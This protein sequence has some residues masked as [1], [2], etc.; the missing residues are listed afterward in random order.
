MSALRG[1]SN[2]G[3]DLG[4]SSIKWGTL[5]VGDVQAETMTTSGNVEIQGNL[6]VTGTQTS[7]QVST[8]EA[9]DPLIKLARGN[10]GDTLDIGF[11]GQSNDGSA[12]YHGLFRDQ[13]DSGK[14]KLFKDLVSE[15]S[16]TVGT[17][18]SSHKATLVAHLEGNVTGDL[19][20][21]ADTATALET[22]RNIAVSGDI[23]GT[24]SFDGTGNIS[25]A[26]TIQEDAV[27]NSMILNPGYN[28][29]DG[30]TPGLVELGN[31]ITIQGTSNEVEV[32]RSSGTFTVG[33]PSTV[34]GLSS[35]SA[36]ALA[37]ELTGNASTATKLAT[38]RAIQISGDV[39]GSA[40][41]DGSAAINIAATIQSG[42][43]ENSMLANDGITLTVDGTGGED[44]NLG[45]SLDFNGTANQVAIAYSAANNDLTFSLP[46]T[47]NVDTSGNAATAT[48]QE[49]ARNFSVSSTE[50]TADAIS[51]DG[52]GNVA[53]D[54]ALKDGTVANSRLANSSITFSDGSNSSA[55]SLGQ[56]LTIQGTSNEVEVG[57]SSGTFTIGLPSTITAAVNGNA[58]TA[59]ALASARNFEINAGP[60]R[61]AAVSFDGTGNCQLTSSIAN[62]QITNAMLQNDKLVIQVDSV[63]YDRAL[64]S[65]L[66]FA[67]GGDLTVNYSASENEITYSLPSNISSDTSG[68]AATAT[69]L[70]TGR[71]IGIT[72]GPVRAANITFDGSGNVGLTSSIAAGQISNTMLA[73]DGISITVD[74]SAAEDIN[75][76]DS[77]DFNGTANQIS[78]GYSSGGNDL[79]WSLPSEINVD[80]SGNAATATALETARNFE[81]NAGPVRAAAVSF[82]GTGNLQLTSSIASGQITNTML[83]NSSLTFSDGS[84]SSAVALGGT[85]TI[86]GTSNEVEVGESS[87]TYTIGLPSTIT[88]A[89]NGNAATA[90]AWASSR[91]LSL[92]GDLGG[93]VAIDGSADATLTATIQAGSVENS[94]LANS[95]I[96]VGGTAVALGG[97]MNV[98][99]TSSEIDVSE[100]GGTFT[101]GL[102]N[103]VNIT[104]NLDVGGNLTLSGAAVITGNITASGQLSASGA[105]ISFADT[106]IELGVNN[107]SAKDHGFYSQRS[108]GAFCGFAFD[109]TDDKFKVFTTDTEPSTTVDDS[110]GGYSLAD[111]EASTI[112]A[113]STLE[114]ALRSS[115]SAP[116]SASASGTAGDIRFDSNKLYVCVSTNTWKAVDLSTF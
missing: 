6:T 88:A 73:N 44:I 19:T 36:T 51:Y 13:S 5:H 58:S 40:N 109:E 49:T 115:G 59:T 103:S 11:Y 92:G 57:E 2:K 45:D 31:Q 60:V 76:G 68:N 98:Q 22:A 20:G 90:S 30:N 27:E 83:D 91:T 54:I 55:R 33:L 50:M 95:S 25:I 82:D 32:S 7:L 41:F 16:T 71:S 62:D 38:T 81:I 53:L 15:P 24:A 69:A 70:E 97:S 17:L 35:V 10:T 105:N 64:G 61:A 29:S 102:P 1:D 84:N 4:T 9:E 66:K 46:S 47:I 8:V 114:G 65:T 77:L 85:L 86:Q 89:L 12:K 110:Q 94:M 74:G 52:T 39:A 87:G 28:F 99:G 79:T 111:F 93:S 18:S 3:H 106:L 23:S 37:G 14:F 75:L 26:S 42:A 72:A 67:K 104:S 78:I 48:A 80:T 34:S 116:A 107:T 101:V 108:S 100:S 21:N 112:K 56:T 96:T 113:N 43:V 63:D